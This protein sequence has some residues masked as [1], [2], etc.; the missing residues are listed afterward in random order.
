M[1]TQ[2]VARQGA[3]V[4]GRGKVTAAQW[5]AFLLGE[6]VNGRTARE[7]LTDP[8]Q[9]DRGTITG[10]F[11]GAGELQ[12][13]ERLGVS[14]AAA[15]LVGTGKVTQDE[16]T[17]RLGV[18]KGTVS[19]MVK[20]GR[21]FILMGEQL[22]RGITAGDLMGA[23][24]TS[25]GSEIGKALDEAQKDGAKPDAV[26]RTLTDLIKA[27]SD[28][29]KEQRNKARE[30]AG[31]PREAR[32]NDGTGRSGSE[33]NN[34]RTG[35]TAPARS[36]KSEA[37]DK[38]DAAVAFIAENVADFSEADRARVENAARGILDLLS[39]SKG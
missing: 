24:S 39:K 32:P 11:Q 3:S 5:S 35:E 10:L 33:G 23:V 6:S 16:F 31:Q 38:L 20:A 7:L 21:A 34:G 15:L 2:D 1:A 19:K 13:A 29:Q 12:R 4:E 28:K 9:I 14:A 22:P 25:Y 17:S 26:R 18:T 8:S 27:G 30:A 36:A 37:F